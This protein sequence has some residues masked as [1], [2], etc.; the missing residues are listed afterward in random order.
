[1]S[2]HFQNR[3]SE[4]VWHRQMIYHSCCLSCLLTLLAARRVSLKTSSQKENSFQTRFPSD[5]C[6][7]GSALSVRR[8]ICVSAGGASG[9]RPSG[10]RSNGSC[11]LEA[12]LLEMVLLE[13]IPIEGIL[14]HR[15]SP[16]ASACRSSVFPGEPG[17]INRDPP[18]N[19]DPKRC[20]L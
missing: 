18:I 7:L 14:L 16:T 19:H 13:V 11:L 10:S 9:S 6:V 20:Y 1:M 15:I 3:F 8:L 5:S 17:R 2:Y 4:T 12:L